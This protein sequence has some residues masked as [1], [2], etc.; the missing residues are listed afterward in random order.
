[1]M[2]ELYLS[3][4]KSQSCDDVQTFHN[5]DVIKSSLPDEL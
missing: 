5:D 2:V 3:G 1:M 4:V